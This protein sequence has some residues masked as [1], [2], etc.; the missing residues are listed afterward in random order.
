MKTQIFLKVAYHQALPTHIMWLIISLI[1]FFSLFLLTNLYS[2]IFN[3]FMLLFLAVINEVIFQHLNFTFL[4]KFD[5]FKINLK[6]QNCFLLCLIMHLNLCMDEISEIN[7][8]VFQELSF[9]F[10]SF[11]NS[12]SFLNLIKFMCLSNS[13]SSCYF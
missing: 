4:A 9:F 1:S 7:C 6:I 8:E 11:N 13:L 10:I 12:Y 5:L 2:L 3:L